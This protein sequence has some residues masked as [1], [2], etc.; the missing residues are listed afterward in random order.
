MHRFHRGLCSTEVSFPLWSSF[1]P[2]SLFPSWTSLL[3]SGP[4]HHGDGSPCV[5]TGPSLLG[6]R[7]SLPWAIVGPHT[8][9][10]LVVPHRP[11]TAIRFHGASL[12][13]I[14]WVLTPRPFSPGPYLCWGPFL[15]RG[16]FVVEIF[17]G[18]RGPHWNHTHAGTQAPTRS[19]HTSAHRCGQVGSEP[20]WRVELVGAGWKSLRTILSFR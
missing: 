6:L 5:L 8:H 15:R 1:L 20:C 9:R 17:T 3:F 13:V 19:T 4:C 11:L 7:A 18:G 16:L 14:P 12:D 2:R 10:S